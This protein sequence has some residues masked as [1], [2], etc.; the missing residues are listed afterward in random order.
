MLVLL[1]GATALLP[2]AAY[3]QQQ[4]EKLPTIGSRHEYAFNPK[5]WTAAFAQRLC[6]LGWSEDR[7]RA[8]RYR[9]TDGRTERSIERPSAVCG[10]QTRA[11]TALACS[12][13]P[14]SLDE[15][16]KRCESPDTVADDLG[17]SQHRH[18][19]DRTKNA[20]H[21]IP[22]D[23]RQD[24]QHRVDREALGEQHRGDGLPFYDVDEHVYTR[25]DECQPQSLD[26]QQA[27]KDQDCHPDHRTEDRHIIEQESNSA[28]QHRVAHST[29]GGHNSRSDADTEVH[30]SDRG[31]IRGDV[32][33]DLLRN[34][35]RLALVFEPR[36]YFNKPTQE[37]IA[38]DKQEKQHQHGRE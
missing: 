12:G 20:P 11:A 15:M 4:P 3:P 32:R 26:R 25:W 22:E 14:L 19:E 6:E 17:N 36:Q 18:S 21:P 2:I 8:L 35:D 9:W 16:A 24:D 31:E 5:L 34:I 27:G 1:G 37:N 33:F 30:E 13:W 10:T 38:G 7:R 29:C 28:P 23:Q